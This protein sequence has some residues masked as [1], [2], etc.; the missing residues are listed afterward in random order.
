MVTFIYKSIAAFAFTLSLLPFIGCNDMTGS[1]NVTSVE[2]TADDLRVLRAG[3]MLPLH[4]RDEIEYHLDPSA[5]PLDLSKVALFRDE[6]GSTIS[7]Q[8]VLV[9]APEFK[10]MSPERL[11]VAEVTLST[12]DGT[13]DH[14]DF[15]KAD[16]AGCVGGPVLIF[17][18]LVW[19]IICL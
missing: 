14:V 1:A 19:V 13:A 5:G 9:N 4:I 12:V 16:A 18:A 7:M 15:R 2:V 8:D 6:G 10:G 11:G 17:G 3:E